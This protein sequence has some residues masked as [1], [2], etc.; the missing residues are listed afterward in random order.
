M[1]SLLSS[2]QH[3]KQ[4][5]QR[6]ISGLIESL[7]PFSDGVWQAFRTCKSVFL[8][9]QIWYFLLNHSFFS[10]S[11]GTDRLLF[12]AADGVPVVPGLHAAPGSVG[13]LHLMPPHP[14]PLLL[15]RL[16]PLLLGRSGGAHGGAKLPRPLP[17]HA[18]SV[19]LWVDRVSGVLSGVL[20]DLT[21]QLGSSLT[22]RPQD[23]FIR[24]DGAER[25][26]F[27]IKPLWDLLELQWQFVTVSYWPCCEPLN[28]WTAQNSCHTPQY[29]VITKLT[30]NAAKT[31]HLYWLQPFWSQSREERS[32]LS[33]W[34]SNTGNFMCL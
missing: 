16:H 15:P 9:P 19:L 8:W 12:A 24:R 7:I 23:C 26:G 31:I 29:F 32:D 33:A 3:N 13:G 27:E 5:Y 11:C 6:L 30:P 4:T 20:R 1:V 17:L 21:S 14:L 2:A 28:L 34:R 22:T 18:G 25:T 10:F